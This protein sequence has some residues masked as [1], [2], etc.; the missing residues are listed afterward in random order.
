MKK[1]IL[2][3][4]GIL[5]AGAVLLL[6]VFLLFCFSL[7]PVEQVPQEGIWYCEELKLQIN[8]E[9]KTQSNAYILVD[10]EKILCQGGNDR[11]SPYLYVVCAETRYAA[12]YPNGIVFSGEVISHNDE[13][14]I[15]QELD[16]G[17]EYTFFRTDSKYGIS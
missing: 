1:S 16:T 8:F 3:S 17:A 2:F 11:G 10:G 5:I 12:D 4:L 6:G 7:G 15:A 14:F 13:A 9:Q